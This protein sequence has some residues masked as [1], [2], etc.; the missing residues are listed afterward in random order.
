M[1]KSKGVAT[2][3]LCFKKENKIPCSKIGCPAKSF[4]VSLYSINNQRS[5]NHA[6]AAITKNY[7]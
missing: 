2:R 1:F 7:V 5:I 3:L 4:I 6:N